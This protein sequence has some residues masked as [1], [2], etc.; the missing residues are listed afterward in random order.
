MDDLMG[1]KSTPYQLTAYHI[2][3]GRLIDVMPD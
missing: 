3:H 1:Q 2:H